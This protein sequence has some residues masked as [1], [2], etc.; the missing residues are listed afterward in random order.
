[1]LSGEQEQEISLEGLKAGTYIIRA[2]SKGSPVE[3]Q[4]VIL[5]SNN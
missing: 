1:M 5:L 3:T 4:K 2:T